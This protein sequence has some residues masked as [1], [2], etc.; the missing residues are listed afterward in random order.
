MLV[1]HS[2]SFWRCSYSNKQ[3]PAVHG[4]HRLC[5]Q[6]AP[7]V[8][9]CTQG[10]A[11]RGQ[12]CEQQLTALRLADKL[13]VHGGPDARLRRHG[14]QR[15]RQRARRAQ[16]GRQPREQQAGAGAR[17]ARGAQLVQRLLRRGRAGRSSDGWAGRSRPRCRRRRWR[18][19]CCRAGRLCGVEAAPLSGA[20]AAPLRTLQ[21]PQH[22]RAG[23]G[24]GCRTSW[25]PARARR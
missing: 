15:Q 13:G 24:V 10:C 14:E 22:S 1:L 5:A 3:S 25:V 11:P 2:H 23:R 20:G 21:P 8:R 17:A 9:P 19:T 16:H 6:R 7:G 18:G 4:A 12:G